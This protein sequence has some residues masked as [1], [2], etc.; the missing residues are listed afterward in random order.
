MLCDRVCELR[1]ILKPPTA[2]IRI[3][4]VD[5]GGIRGIVPLEFLSVLQD[6]L[7][8][9]CLVQDMFD[10]AFGT[11]AGKQEKSFVRTET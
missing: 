9:G 3:L 10:L 2:G 8:Q 4:S 5:G 7:G 6:A 11:S 1:V